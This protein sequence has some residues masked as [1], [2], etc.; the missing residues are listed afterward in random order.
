[1]H[2]TTNP[3]T[4]NRT[5]RQWCAVA[6]TT[7]EIINAPSRPEVEA[8]YLAAVAPELAEKVRRI[9]KLS[10]E[11]ERRARRAAFLVIEGAVTL[12]GQGVS[13]GRYL[14]YELA[15]VKSQTGEAVYSVRVD[16]GQFYCTCPD[17]TGEHPQAPHSK[18]APH[19]CK[20]IISY[21]MAA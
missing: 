8:Q 21:L 10:P 2:T 13:E 9:A 20:H 3:I 5:A 11:L 12:T 7:G 16:N 4:Y 18:V 15:R 14:H 19:T 6:A 1:M 17:T